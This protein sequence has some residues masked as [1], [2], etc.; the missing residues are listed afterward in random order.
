MMA[1][2]MKITL[3]NNSVSNN[4]ARL[5]SYSLYLAWTLVLALCLQSRRFKK[6]YIVWLRKISI[7]TLQMEILR[8]RRFWGLKEIIFWREGVTQ[9]VFFPVALKCD[10]MAL[11]Y[12]FP[13]IQLCKPTEMSHV[14]VKINIRFFVIYYFLLFRHQRN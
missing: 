9:R 5:L 4:Q 8:G 12:F 11:L 10:L 7:W 3:F 6:W 14:P 1:T 13:S 2:P